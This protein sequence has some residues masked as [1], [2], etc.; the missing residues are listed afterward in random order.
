LITTQ[1]AKIEAGLMAIT[2]FIFYNADFHGF[3]EGDDTSMG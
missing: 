2:E 3:R 1:E